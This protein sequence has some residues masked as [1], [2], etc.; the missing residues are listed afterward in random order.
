MSEALPTTL[1]VLAGL[2]LVLVLTTLWQSVRGVLLGGGSQNQGTR[3]QAA[4]ERAGLLREKQELLQAIRDV[5]FEH[6]L[7]KLSDGDCERLEA[8]YRARAREVLEALD[9]QLAPHRDEARALL[10]ERDAGALLELDQAKSSNE[11]S[12]KS[13]TPREPEPHACASCGTDNDADAVFC[14]KC[15]GKLT[16]EERA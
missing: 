13:S 12:D 8:R 4:G 3:T 7:G 5:R 16:S 11:P 9:A 1:A 2:C 15:G 6:E 10:G 14:K